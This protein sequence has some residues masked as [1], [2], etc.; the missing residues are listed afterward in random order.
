M[1][2]VKETVVGFVLILSNKPPKGGTPYWLA[3]W[4]A[5]GAGHLPGIPTLVWHPARLL[6]EGDV[7]DLCMDTMHL[8]DPLILFGYTSSALISPSFSSFT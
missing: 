8:K 3:Q 1:L 2:F 7:V 6:K 4:C 5:I